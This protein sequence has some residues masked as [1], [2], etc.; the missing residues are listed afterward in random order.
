MRNRGGIGI[1]FQSAPRARARGDLVKS[2]GLSVMK[3]FQSA[4]RARARGDSGALLRNRLRGT[5]GF[6]PRPAHARGA[7]GNNRGIIGIG[8]GFNPRPAH[9][10]GATAV[11]PTSSA[12]K[13]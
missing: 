10:R 2:A 13:L 9:A 3:L 11:L 8:E 6:N 5:I 1:G 7:T 12:A 4:P